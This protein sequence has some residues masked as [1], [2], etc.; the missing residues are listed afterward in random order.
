[1]TTAAL[2]RESARRVE[3]TIAGLIADKPFYGTLALRLPVSADR[4]VKSVA[5]NG[6]DI[7]YNPAWVST[8]SADDLFRVVAH[9]VLGCVL[10]HHTR[11]G[12]RSYARWQE[13]SRAVTLP[14]LRADGLTSD[15]G[16]MDMS[17]EDAYEQ[18]PEPPEDED[19]EPNE[20]EGE[21]GGGGGAIVRQ[22]GGDGQEAEGEGGGDGQEGEGEGGGQSSPQKRPSSYDP[23]GQ[24]EIMDSPAGDGKGESEQEQAMQSEEQDWD[25]WGQQAAQLGKAQGRE[26]G[27]MAEMLAASHQSQ[28]DWRDL[29]RRFMTSNTKEDYSWSRPNR[30]LIDE[31]PYMPA[32]H[33][34]SMEDVVFAIDT[35]GSMRSEVLSA[36]WTEIRD[37]AADVE[38]SQ[39]IVIQCDTQVNSVEQYEPHGT[40]DQI[41]ML[42]RGGTEFRPV[43]DAIEELGIRPAA[44][45]YLTDLGVYG[46]DDYPALEPIYPVLWVTYD[47]PPEEMTPPWGERIDIDMEEFAKS[48]TVA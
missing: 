20:Q 38:P 13:A 14:I 8:A 46:G 26:S 37:A 12:G 24:G 15:G 2:R 44:L 11:R 36:V 48:A 33:S 47:E 16:G 21:G 35:S 25:E 41:E 19:G 32:L 4:K 1:M 40:P 29:L 22:R 10:K 17:V 5:T 6:K 18:I 9:C 45:I 31:G 42:G 30:R 43:F 3:R 34:P 39:V 27:H 7:Y 28:L 23:K